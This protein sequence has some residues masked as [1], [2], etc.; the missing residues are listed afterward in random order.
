[1][2]DESKE[3]LRAS[4]IIWSVSENYT[5]QPEAKVLDDSGKADLYW[6]YIL[7]A[8]Y[9]Y[10]DYSKFEQFFLQLKRYEN[11]GFYQNLMWIGL[12]NSI[13]EKGQKDR[14]VLKNIREAYA[15]QITD[16]NAIELFEQIKYEH[17]KKV[18]GQKVRTGGALETLVNDLNFDTSLNTDQVILKM[19]QILKEYFA[20]DPT[21]KDES[22]SGIRLKLRKPGLFGWDRGSRHQGNPILKR[23]KK[24]N[25]KSTGKLLKDEQKIKNEFKLYWLKYLERRK[26]NEREYINNYFGNSFLS[27]QETYTLEQ[28]LCTDNHKG[29]HLHFTRGEYGNSTDEVYYQKE[30][31]KQ[32]EQNKIYYDYN[33][34]RNNLNIIK[35][36]NRIKNAILFHQEESWIRGKAG[37]LLADKVWKNLYLNETRIFRRIIPDSAV[38]F[39]VDIMLDASASQMYRQETIAEEAYIIAE[40]LTRCNIPVRVYSF[41]NMRNHTIFH[42]YR[43]YLEKNGNDNIFNYY[44]AGFNR[45]GLAIRT[46]L[47][48]MENNLAD[49]KMLILLSD[50][51]PSDMQYIASDNL[52]MIPKEYTGSVGVDDTAREV[53]KGRKNG[54]PILCVYTGTDD[55]APAIKKIYG[56]NYVRIPTPDRFADTVGVM[57]LNELA[58]L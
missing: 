4:N 15:K 39:T 32:R 57:I 38:N 52:T 58:N 37:S 13:Y 29:C 10:Y 28:L 14:P 2:D 5:F 3:L 48:G 16:K 17:F 31:I 22:D 8:A 45:D 25:A 49:K 55:D 44:A 7:G 19:E 18:L 33:A 24:E 20:Y 40:S 47:H 12:E 30:A 56:Q 9:K 1:M 51:N 27:E 36:T 6:N 41:C 46:A 34:T 23:F 26:K 53:R 11:S 35:L 21:A 43:D 42:R 54:I 50:G